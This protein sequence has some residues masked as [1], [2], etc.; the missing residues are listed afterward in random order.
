MV[1]YL[2]VRMYFGGNSDEPR[3]D[4]IRKHRIHNY[5]QYSIQLL[6]LTTDGFSRYATGSKPATS[7][8]CYSTPTVSFKY[9]CS[10][11]SCLDRGLKTLD[12]ARYCKFFLDLKTPFNIQF[13]T[14]INFRLRHMQS[15]VGITKATVFS[16]LV[17]NLK[18]TTKEYLTPSKTS[19]MKT[20]LSH[21]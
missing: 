19:V 18:D 16:F 5:T 15:K 12:T 17:K 3:R 6:L 4:I 2:Y 20:H 7:S 13:V 8:Q 1:L 14:A 11:P 9:T 21:W 10:R